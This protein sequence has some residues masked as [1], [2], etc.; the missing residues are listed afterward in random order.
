MEFIANFYDNIVNACME[1]SN[2]SIPKSSPR[3]NV[4]GWS[5]LVQPHKERAVFWHRVWNSIGGNRQGV[6]YDIMLRT[7]DNYERI[8]CQSILRRLIRRHSVASEK[9]A[10]S[11]INDI[12]EAMKCLHQADKMPLFAVPSDKLRQILLA[13]PSEAATVS[14]CE[15]LNMLEA[16]ME[17]HEKLI[18]E[19]RSRVTAVNTVPEQLPS[20]SASM[21]ART[22]PEATIPVATHQPPPRPRDPAERPRKQNRKQ[23]NDDCK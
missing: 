12:M 22:Y 11:T 2:E 6:V 15:R 20:A 17:K 10:M 23:W 1:S 3:R 16:R 13:K 21:S 14:L 5:E 7:K 18:A 19:N 4:A 9:G 8:S